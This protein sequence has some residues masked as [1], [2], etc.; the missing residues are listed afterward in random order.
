MHLKNEKKSFRLVS[1]AKSNISPASR[2]F[3]LQ[4]MQSEKQ[5]QQTRKNK[6]NI[7]KQIAGSSGTNG[8]L[9]CSDS[10]GPGTVHLSSKNQKHQ[11]IQT[12]ELATITIPIGAENGV[13]VEAVGHGVDREIPPRE[14]TIIEKYPLFRA[15]TA[16]IVRYVEIYS[17]Q[18]HANPKHMTPKESVG[19]AQR[20][21][22][23]IAVQVNKAFPQL[24]ALNS[25]QA[26]TIYS[27]FIQAKSVF[28]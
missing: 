26:M 13:G 7:K 3:K 20:T 2:P 21:W 10:L 24:K 19:V 5:S 12:W 28:K 14:L 25:N 11:P 23:K 6:K 1:F 9:I 16:L 4:R 17:N 22:P 8:V 15:R 18:L 27:I